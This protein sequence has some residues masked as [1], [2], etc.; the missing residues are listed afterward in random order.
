[1]PN[2]SRNTLFAHAITGG[3]TSPL[4]FNSNAANLTLGTIGAGNNRLL[5][6]S[7]N[8][9]INPGTQTVTCNGSAMT[10][11]GSAT[12]DGVDFIQLYGIIAPATGNAA[13]VVTWSGGSTNT[14]LVTGVCYN[15]TDQTTGWIDRGNGDTGSASPASSTVTTSNGNAV[16]VSHSN[17]NASSTTLTAGTT[18]SLYVAGQGN[19]A[20]ADVLSTGS[21]ATVTWTLGSAVN[22]AHRKVDI[23]ATNT[24]VTYDSTF[25]KAA[26]NQASPFSYVS[27]AGTVA[28]TVGANSN[29]ALVAY[30][31]IRIPDG[32]RAQNIA[33]TWNGVAMTQ[34]GPT[35][36]TGS[37]VLTK[38]GLIAPATGAQTISVSWTGGN[39]IVVL[40][41]VSLY[42]VEQTVGF[43]DRGSDT[44]NTSPASS[45]VTTAVNNAVVVHHYDEN[46]ATLTNTAGIEAWQELALTGTG[47][48]AM[49]YKLS[50]SGSE[51]ITWTLGSDV[52]WYN[53]KVDVLAFGS[54][55]PASVQPATPIFLVTA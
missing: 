7:V 15:D 26:S 27:N 49:A 46:C 55:P 2:V 24:P 20:V 38:W 39:A 48:Y 47:K 9:R 5:V 19:H 14:I 53:D 54:T 33:V 29:R 23:L 1:M 6:I 52:L 45:A 32:T 28:G 40:G 4:S 21:T 13:I 36:A 37:L 16:L 12:N 44:G 50:A 34:I 41:A 8:Q 3:Q 42:S 18:V 17:N 35:V 31:L 22:W 43:V 30:A 25:E 11:I 51:I 10:E